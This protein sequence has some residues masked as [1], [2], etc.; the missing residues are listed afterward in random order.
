MSS[1]VK[2]DP[3]L[4]KK[5]LE[6]IEAYIENSSN[7]TFDLSRLKSLVETIK[8]ALDAQNDHLET[9]AK[10]STS[11]DWNL[12]HRLTV[13]ESSQTEI[14]SKI[15][16]LKSDTSNIKSMMTENY[17]AFKEQIQ[18]HLDKED[19]IKKAEEDAKTFAMTKTKVIKIVQKEVEKIGIDLKKV[20][21][22]KAGKRYERLKKI[23]E[24]LGIQSTLPAP[25]L[26]QDQSQSSGRKKKHVKLESKIKVPGLECNRSHPKCVPFVN[27]M[28]IEELEY[29][30][31]FTDMF[32]DQAFQR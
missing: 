7:I 10:S 21:S 26:E 27:N 30:I 13:I 20:I 1:S 15:S 14:R 3:A 19:Q 31:F 25:V 18:A 16:S 8:A 32:G 6:A 28:V 22:A 23:P 5:V 17:Q 9:W 11:M 4:N 24:E 2:E 29:E 12:G